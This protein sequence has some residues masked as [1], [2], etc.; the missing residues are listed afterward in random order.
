MTKDKKTSS[1]MESTH[2]LNELK[3]MFLR[4]KVS[5]RTCGMDIWIDIILETVETLRFTKKFV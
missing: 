4:T 3:I 1:L 2:K 5:I